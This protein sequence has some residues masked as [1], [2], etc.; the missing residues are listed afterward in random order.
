MNWGGGR[1]KKDLKNKK[2]ITDLVDIFVCISALGVRLYPVHSSPPLSN[3]DSIRS[4]E[5]DDFA[6]YQR[7]LSRALQGDGGSSPDIVR[8]LLVQA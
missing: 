3:R 4:L 5:H 1:H 2:L 8:Y 6:A 7:E